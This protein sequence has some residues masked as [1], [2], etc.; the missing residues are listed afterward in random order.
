MPMATRH[1]SIGALPSHNAPLHT[2]SIH[3]HG[4][5]KIHFPS[6][7]H[8]LRSED[9]GARKNNRRTGCL[10]ISMATLTCTGTGLVSMLTRTHAIMWLT[11]IM[12]SFSLL[13]MTETNIRIYF[14][15]MQERGGRGLVEAPPPRLVWFVYRCSGVWSVSKAFSWWRSQVILVIL[16]RRKH[17][18]PLPPART[19]AVSSCSNPA[20]LPPPPPQFHPLFQRQK[21]SWC[22][23]AR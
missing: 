9:D 7:L 20:D 19:S 14:F 1:Q 3:C 8:H 6:A 10:S 2:Q 16:G 5:K 12:S 4:G 11:R 18:P 21:R 23:C 22:V 17:T 15:K 13:S